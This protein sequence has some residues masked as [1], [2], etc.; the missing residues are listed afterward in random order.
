M[1]NDAWKI[2][3]AVAPLAGAWIEISAGLIRTDN[4]SVA[5]LAGAWIEIMLV[6]LEFTAC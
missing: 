6:L 2:V 4:L 5:P 3:Y 1:W